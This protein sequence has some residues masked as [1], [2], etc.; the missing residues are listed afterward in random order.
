MN[1][2]TKFNW[3]REKNNDAFKS[4]LFIEKYYIL[5]QTLMKF[6]PKSSIN[7]KPA[8]VPVIVWHRTDYKPLFEPT[9]HI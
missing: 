1:P 5:I 9:M 3:V 4:I 8:L 7:E 2:V 6:V